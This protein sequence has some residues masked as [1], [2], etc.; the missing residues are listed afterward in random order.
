MGREVCVSFAL[1]ATS[2]L[3]AVTRVIQLLF[4]IYS[5]RDKQE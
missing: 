1:V 2:T 5:N 4:T 3:T